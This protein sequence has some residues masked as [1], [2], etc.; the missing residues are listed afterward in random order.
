MESFTITNEPQLFSF[1]EEITSRI[2]KVKPGN[3]LMCELDDEPENVFYA[4]KVRDE[5]PSFLKIN[6][7]PS[8]DNDSESE[9]ERDSVFLRVLD[10]EG[11]DTIQPNNIFKLTIDSGHEIPS[12]QELKEYEENMECLHAL[13]S[14]I[15]DINQGKYMEY[16]FEE[17][18]KISHTLHP[19]DITKEHPIITLASEETK[20]QLTLQPTERAEWLDKIKQHGGYVFTQEEYEGLLDRLDTNNK[21]IQ[22]YISVIE[23][24]KNRT[25]SEYTTKELQ[26]KF[27]DVIK[28]YI[29]KKNTHDYTQGEGN[30]AAVALLIGFEEYEALSI[31][32]YLYDKGIIKTCFGKD[33]MNN[34]LN[35]FQAT[36][37]LLTKLGIHYYDKHIDDDMLSGIFIP[38][39]MGKLCTFF[40]QNLPVKQVMILMKNYI[41]NNNEI[42]LFGTYIN[43]IT[44]YLGINDY[45]EIDDIYNKLLGKKSLKQPVDLNKNPKITLEQINEFYEDLKPP[46]PLEPQEPQEPLEQPQEPLT[47]KNRIIEYK[48]KIKDA[49]QK[50]GCTPQTL[51]KNIGSW[52]CYID[53]ALMLLFYDPSVLV[54]REI[55]FK[56]VSSF[57][58]EY[59]QR[60][61]IEEIQ[62]F[63]KKLTDQI[64]GLSNK[65]EILTKCVPLVKK[66][67]DCGIGV[68]QEKIGEVPQERSQSSTEFINYLFNLFQVP[69]YVNNNIENIGEIL[70]YMHLVNTHDF[71]HNKIYQHDTIPS[72]TLIKDREDLLLIRIQNVGTNQSTPNEILKTTYDE[73]TIYKLKGVLINS[74]KKEK[75][76]GHYTSYIRCGDEWYL[77]ND[78]PKFQLKPTFKRIGNYKDM[79]NGLYKEPNTPEIFVYQVDN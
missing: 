44:E 43:Y 76:S 14:H 39:F 34:K 31:L 21:Q 33:M 40:S 73:H 69:K 56:D 2:T 7:P 28:A 59:T 45:T 12:L 58:N 9:H 25:L 10:S 35:V 11:N 5:E 52:S 29:S 41:Y 55:L 3:L 20:E 68:L 4:L 66:M 67:K 77:Y 42:E 49:R 8:R 22:N 50:G 13:L 62:E 71:A 16:G 17:D 6:G 48:Q 36:N 1:N 57:Y 75:K 51:L 23:L 37:N 63:L 27:M 26:S 79:I 47:I 38:I 78:Q 15:S 65:T 19:V 32:Y 24:D 30:A 72:K 54:L 64:N 53:S 18:C 61:E 74:T 46:Q 60:C 70:E